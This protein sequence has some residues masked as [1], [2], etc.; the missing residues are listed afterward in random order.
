[1]FEI[2]FL[3]SVPYPFEFHA[4]THLTQYLVVS[5]A[6][7]LGKTHLKRNYSSLCGS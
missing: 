7:I 5:D 6:H 3:N 4:E 1:M 2:H